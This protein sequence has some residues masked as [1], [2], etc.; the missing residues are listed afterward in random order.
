MDTAA[1][2]I[3]RRALDLVIADLEGAAHATA[4]LAE[5][6]RDTLMAGRTLLQQAAPTTF[7]LKAAGWLSGLDYALARLADVRRHRLAVQ[8]GGAAGTLAYLGD[9]GVAVVG[10]LAEELGLAAP[11]LP[12]HTA[13]GRIVELAGALGEAASAAAKVAR[14]ITLLAQTEVG[15][16]REGQPGGSSTLPQKQNPIAAVSVLACAARAPGLVATLLAAAV[17]EHERA[18]GAWHAEWA[19]L[20]DLLVAVGSAA[21]WLR[22]GLAH[23]EVDAARMRANVDAGGGLILAERVA[24]A[25]APALGRLRAHE[26]VAAASAAA[27][28]GARPFGEVLAADPA[29]TAHLDPGRLATLLDPAGYLGSAQAFIDRALAA[30]ARRR[31]TS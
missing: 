19:P 24:A 2:L 23:L 15:E 28:A 1:L 22:D 14:D 10:Y 3:A 13:R 17:Q 7:G 27:V 25:L 29:V 26:L 5:R 16:V 20:R 6:H 11:A 9:A 31:G 18:A 30:H 21:A 12:W 8:L 4:T